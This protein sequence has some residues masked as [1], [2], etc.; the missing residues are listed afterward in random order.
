MRSVTY[1][2]RVTYVMRVVRRVSH[3]RWFM[4]ERANM[5]KTSVMKS[6]PPECCLA[7]NLHNS[8]I[9]GNRA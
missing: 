4:N 2:T 5:M 3:V 1:V 7:A 8:D 6:K 9:A